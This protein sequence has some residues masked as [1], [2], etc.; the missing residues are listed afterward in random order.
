MDDEN[1]IDQD[2]SNSFIDAQPT[3]W[4]LVWKHLLNTPPK[5]KRT[6]IYPNPNTVSSTIATESEN[7]N[8]T[9]D[10]WIRND[11][12]ENFASNTR[13]KYFGGMIP[14]SNDNDK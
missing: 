11:E 7:K 12:S 14:N 13:W 10:S 2:I 8:V 1:E 4:A 6:R 5:K 9:N 3:S